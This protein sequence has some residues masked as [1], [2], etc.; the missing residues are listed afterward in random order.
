[1]FVLPL[2][3]FRI[4]NVIGFR[5][6]FTLLKNLILILSQVYD[7]FG[8]LMELRTARAFTVNMIIRFNY[9]YKNQNGFSQHASIFFPFFY[10]W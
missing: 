7:N 3:I 1:M 9:L 2:S 8:R 5:P 10:M 6:F 4:R